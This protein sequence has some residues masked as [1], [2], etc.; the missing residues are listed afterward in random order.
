MD[1]GRIDSNLLNEIRNGNTL[2]EA[3]SKEF[4]MHLDA[5]RKLNKI[6]TEMQKLMKDYAKESM[7]VAENKDKY[8]NITKR[9]ENIYFDIGDTITEIEYLKDE[10]Q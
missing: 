4:K 7:K 9:L 10:Y 6:A 3:V 2:N 5:S 8:M 1:Y